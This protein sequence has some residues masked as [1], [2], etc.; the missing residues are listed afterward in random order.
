MNQVRP[1]S[2]RNDDRRAKSYRLSPSTIELIEQMAEDQKTSKYKIV[3]RAIANM[4]QPSAC[5]Q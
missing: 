1:V 5:P 3:E 2:F 4:A